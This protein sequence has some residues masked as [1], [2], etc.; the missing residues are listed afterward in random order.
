MQLG[1]LAGIQSE[2]TKIGFT[3]RK[4]AAASSVEFGAQFELRAGTK[5]RFAGGGN[6]NLDGLTVKSLKNIRTSLLLLFVF[7]FY[8]FLR[9]KINVAIP[10]VPPGS[11]CFLQV[12]WAGVTAFV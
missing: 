4:T 8:N 7:F 6:G 12:E 9:I 5:N 2:F 1:T 3:G 10:Y 11:S